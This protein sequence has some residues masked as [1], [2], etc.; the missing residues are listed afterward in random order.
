M[1]TSLSPPSDGTR[2]ERRPHRWH[3]CGGAVHVAPPSPPSSSAHVVEPDPTAAAR[4]GARSRGGARGE[5][6]LGGCR[7]RVEPYPPAG[8]AGRPFSA[9]AMPGGAYPVAACTGA[10]DEVG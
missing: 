6:S 7:T 8:R 3:M 10:S 9:V 5:A 4:G 2:G 1:A